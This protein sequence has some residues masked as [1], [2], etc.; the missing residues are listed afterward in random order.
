MLGT[1]LF[2]LRGKNAHTL[3]VQLFTKVG[4]VYSLSDLNYPI[5][6]IFPASP[7]ELLQKHSPVFRLHLLQSS[8]KDAGISR[9][10]AI[11]DTLP[12]CKHV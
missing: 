11:A 2:C 12:N 3:K 8:K 1:S 10:D 6:K 7:A 5:T 4:M 9:G